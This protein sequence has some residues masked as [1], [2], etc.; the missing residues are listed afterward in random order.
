MLQ[1]LRSMSK[2]LIGRVLLLAMAVSFALWGVGDIAG[3]ISRQQVAEVGDRTITLVDYE[4]NLRNEINTYQRMLGKVLT[5]EMTQM[6]GLPGAVLENMINR[7]LLH[8]EAEHLGLAVPDAWVLDEIRA[9]QALLDENGNFQVVLFQEFLRQQ[10]LSEYEFMQRMKRDLARET[11]LETLEGERFV[12]DVLVRTLFLHRNE[13]RTAKVLRFLPDTITDIPAPTDT[14][15]VGFFETHA[16]DFKA[17]EYRTVTYISLARGAMAK[18][19]SVSDTEILEAYE[20]NKQQYIIPE[21]RSVEQILFE[22]QEA[23]QAALDAQELPEGKAF[24]FMGRMQREELPEPTRDVI[25]SLEKDTISAPVQTDFGWHLFR[26]TEIV[27]KTE[28]PLEAVRANIERSL[29]MERVD[30]RLYPL[31]VKLEDALAG[32]ATLREAANALGLEAVTIGPISR[33]GQRP[34]GSE[35]DALPPFRTFL[36]EAFS[37]AEGEEPAVIE[38]ETNGFFALHV[39]AVTPARARALD[40]VRGNVVT[41]WKAFKRDAMLHEVADTAALRIKEGES[42]AAVAEALGGEVS[43]T[44]PFTR[45]A[46]DN[47]ILFT[48]VVQALFVMEQGESTGAFKDTDGSYLV[49]RVAKIIPADP[50]ADTSEM[51]QIRSAIQQSMQEEVGE[52]YRAYLRRKHPV[53]VYD[54][55][56]QKVQF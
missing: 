35:I 33:E 53:T 31:T 28:M 49:A 41:Q 17:P 45:A 47:R 3:G 10:N 6:M 24:E 9:S 21:H 27:S 25:F 4:E 1:S 30:D 11:L 19:I 36:A 7:E 42:F 8:L 38:D 20:A 39:D 29:A 34:D 12:P 26:V 23:A 16:D 43:T 37:M 13:R 18:Q 15:L 5:S 56:Q 52:Q 32:G 2:S 51:Q 40:E 22:T 14:D 54:G 50:D 48:P 44:E 46:T 55:I